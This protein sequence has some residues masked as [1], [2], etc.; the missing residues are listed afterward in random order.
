M[1][2]PSSPLLPWPA[3]PALADP[4][5]LAAS[6]AHRHW[7]AAGALALAAVIGGAALWKGRKDRAAK[8]TPERKA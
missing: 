7:L 6:H 2:P 3:G 1:T 8:K 4:G 5:P